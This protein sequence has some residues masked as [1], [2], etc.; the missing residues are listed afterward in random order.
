MSAAIAVTEPIA[1]RRNQAS[2]KLARAVK[3]TNV[4]R[5]FEANEIIVSKTDLKGH[6]TYVNRAFMAISDFDESELLG[7]PHSMIR[8]PDMPR[9]VFK[10]LWETIQS[11]KEIF[12]YVKNMARNGDHYW[13]FAHVTPSLSATGEILGYHSNRRV[14]ERRVLDGVIV[15]LYSELSSIES[16]DA[17][18]KKGLE[19]SHE[20]LQ[21]LL[22]EKGV[23][24]DQLVFSL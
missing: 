18:R 23:A 7:Q 15:P 13:V 11:R 22:K 12:A 3:P 14:P 6:M 5:K 19:R 4:E 24:Y 8:H 2:R 17:D 10:L 21:A 16:R 20:R 9:C 1:P